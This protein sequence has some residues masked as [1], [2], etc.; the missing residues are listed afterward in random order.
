ME[1][2]AY[3]HGDLRNDLIKAGL[4]LLNEDGYQK[5]SLRNVAKRCNV[6][7][8][9]P[10]RHFKNKDELVTAITIEAIGKFDEALKEAVKIYPDDFEKQLREMGFMYVKFF[11]EN[12][13][14]LHLLFLSDTRNYIAANKEAICQGNF[15]FNT[16]FNCV[17]NLL[18]QKGD[19]ELDIHAFA[20]SHWSLVH[21]L[22]I[23]ISKK[24]YPY[25]GDY[26]DLVR[27][28]INMKFGKS[29]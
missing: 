19:A 9:A 13:D 16:F 12:P 7:H 25:D 5:F 28:I 6:S 2:A 20:L 23:L 3:H 18:A 17:R 26:L 14:Y 29:N 8:T 27:K 21:G 24:D 22:A 15:P 1:K 10:Y 4:K 11:V